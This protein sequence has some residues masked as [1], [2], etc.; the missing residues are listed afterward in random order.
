MLYDEFNSFSSPSKFSVASHGLIGT[1]GPTVMSRA[2]AVF[3]LGHETVDVTL[4]VT[5]FAKEI[6]RMLSAV[7]L[8]YVNFDV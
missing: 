8:E 6:L 4:T 5:S 7:L 3:V 2:V 1:A